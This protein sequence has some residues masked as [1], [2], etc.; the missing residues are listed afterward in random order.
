VVAVERFLGL[1]LLLGVV[2]AVAGVMVAHRARQARVNL[3][4]DER[5]VV[6]VGGAALL[7]FGLGTLP[8]AF[9]FGLRGGA[10]VVLAMTP[11]LACALAGGFWLHST[12]HR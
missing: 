2:V 1:L 8:V 3:A 5:P 12:R 10:A 7:V 11:S 6:G 9:G 4:S